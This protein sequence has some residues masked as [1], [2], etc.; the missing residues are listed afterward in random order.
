[1]K[2]PVPFNPEYSVTPDGKVFKGDKLLKQHTK[3]CVRVSLSR[4]LYLVSEIVATAYLPKPKNAI[5]LVYLD[6]NNLNI[7][8]ENLMWVSDNYEEINVEYVE[9][10]GKNFRHIIDIETKQY[11]ISESGEILNFATQ[12]I[13]NPVCDSIGYA[14]FTYYFRQIDSLKKQTIAVH[15]LVYITYHGQYDNSL[16]EINHIDGNKLNNNISNLEIVSHQ[17]NIIHAVKL[18]LQSR[19]YPDSTIKS[20][21]TMLLHN[22]SWTEI[23]EFLREKHHELNKTT[24]FSLINSVAHNPSCYP[25]L[26]QEVGLVKS[27]TTS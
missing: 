23:Y 5:K 20:I 7:S 12:K 24:A 14:R 22:D 4:K 1:M 6:G 19:K 21:A 13:I 9:F 25:D 11:Y 8:L 17:E 2:K 27:S 26:C 3:G 18:G 16:F 10:N 15:I